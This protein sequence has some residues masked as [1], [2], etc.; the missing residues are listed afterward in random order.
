[1]VRYTGYWLNKKM[2][3]QG[4][5]EDSKAI[6]MRAIGDDTFDGRNLSLCKW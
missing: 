6:G 5:F 2:N 3:G 1:M 4:T